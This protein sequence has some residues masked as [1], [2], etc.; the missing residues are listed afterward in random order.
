MGVLWAF[1]VGQVPAHGADITA[2]RQLDGAS[3]ELQPQHPL[4]H[5][6]NEL[7]PGEDPQEARLATLEVN[8]FGDGGG[9]G[10]VGAHDPHPDIAEAVATCPE[11]GG[12]SIGFAD[13][14]R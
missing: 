10:S 1:G 5:H 3:D 8:R 7:I 14:L 4:V 12:G 11:G 6:G 2:A 9:P 13:H